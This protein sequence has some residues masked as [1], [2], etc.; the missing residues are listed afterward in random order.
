M[1]YTTSY[2]RYCYAAKALLNSKGVKYDEVDVTKDPKMKRKV[3][4]ELGWKTVPIILINDRVIGGYDDLRALE[5][6]KKLDEMLK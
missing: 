3:M 2:C 1:I 4:E 6:E 5:E